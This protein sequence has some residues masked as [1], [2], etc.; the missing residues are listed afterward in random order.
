MAAQQQKPIVV[1]GAG[2]VG[3]ATAIWLQRSGRTVTLIDRDEPGTGS[4]FGN[5]GVL[6]ASAIVP[7][8]TPSLPR[9]A[10]RM[11]FDKNEPLFIRWGSSPRLAPWLLAFLSNC[12]P[13]RV[14]RIAKDVHG[15]TWDAIGEHQSLASGTNAEQYVQPCEYWYLYRDHANFAAES[16]SWGVR[17][18][19]G[20]TWEEL[21]DAELHK[22]QQ[23]FSKEFSLLVRQK[24]GHGRI[25][26]PGLYTSALARSFVR[27]GGSLMRAEAQDFVVENGKINQVVT[28]RGKIDCEQVVLAAGI[29]S[30]KLGRKLGVKRPME[31]LGGYHVDLWE[32]SITLKAPTMVPDAKCIITPM[33]N[34]IRLAGIVELGSLDKG[35]TRAPIE[36]LMKGLRKIMPSLTWKDQ[37][38]WMGYR[39]SFPDSLPV[40]GQAPSYS[41]A[42]VSFGHQGVGM[43]SGARSGRILADL[44]NG[45]K[46]NIDLA[47]YSPSR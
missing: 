17:K 26:D 9:N 33:E 34:R 16:F 13:D 18:E 6:A 42:W 3:L 45:N 14:R 43:T 7:V 47:P 4:S 39:P 8:A 37:T 22:L 2:I 21:E 35:G 32:P 27:S 40:L 28:N 11:L 10:L 1:I 41:N 30:T 46:P 20:F 23:G 19:C 5:A 24:S 44:I 36:L 15:L 29:W 25:S 31:G 38:E 12:A